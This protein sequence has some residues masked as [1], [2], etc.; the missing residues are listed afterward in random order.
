[1]KR[2]HGDDAAPKARV[3]KK[4]DQSIYSVGPNKIIFFRAMVNGKRTMVRPPFR[5]RPRSTRTGSP[6]TS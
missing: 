6:R 5:A 4:I 1:M 3:W 2:K